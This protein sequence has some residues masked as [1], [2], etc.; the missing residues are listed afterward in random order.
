MRMQAAREWILG[1]AALSAVAGAV[2]PETFKKGT[3]FHVMPL[4]ACVRGDTLPEK[5][6]ASAD[7]FTDFQRNHSFKFSYV[8]VKRE[9][10][11]YFDSSS[12]KLANE[13]FEGE[14]ADIGDPGADAGR[15]AGDVCGAES[16]TG[17]GAAANAARE[18]SKTADYAF[19]RFNMAGG[20]ITRKETW[21][22]P[23]RWES[24]KV[25][26]AGRATWQADI[27]QAVQAGQMKI[28]DW[29]TGEAVNPIRRAE[30]LDDVWQTISTDGLNKIVPGQQRGDHPHGG[31]APL[32]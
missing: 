6:I 12:N 8:T 4:G 30:I 28:V 3:G 26:R 7:V 21:R 27:D 31:G 23:Q 18:W 13:V 9:R 32:P 20:N 5:V 15:R 2:D 14:E 11:I 10:V 24:A 17:D 1:F 16:G 22:L 19:S 25:N 29:E